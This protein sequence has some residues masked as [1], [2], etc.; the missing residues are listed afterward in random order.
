MLYYNTNWYLAAVVV[1]YLKGSLREKCLFRAF[2]VRIFP[3]SD[4]IRR[5]TTY[6]SIFSPN[7]GKYGPEKLRIRTLFTQ[8][9]GIE[10]ISNPFHA[11]GLFLHTLEIRKTRGYLIFLGGKNE[12]NIYEADYWPIIRTYFTL[13]YAIMINSI[14]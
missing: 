9:I 11:T 10:G 12:S 5:N 1:K 13:S 7:T 3:H 14:I 8:C 6:L 4:W 2:L